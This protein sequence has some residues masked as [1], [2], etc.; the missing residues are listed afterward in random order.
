[1]SS[2]KPNKP[3]SAKKGA[4]G[5]KNPLP[6]KI[7]EPLARDT[8]PEVIC[9]AR[10]PTAISEGFIVALYARPTVGKPG[11]YRYHWTINDGNQ[12]NSLSVDRHRPWVAHWDTTG[13]RPGTFEATVYM[14]AMPAIVPEV[15]DETNFDRRGLPETFLDRCDISIP[16]TAR[17]FQSGDRVAVSLQRSQV[18]VTSDLALWVVIQRATEA[19]SFDNYQR[20]MDLLLCG[21]GKESRGDAPVS[22]EFHHL[23]KRRSL[24][25]NDADAYRLLKV[26]TE[27]FLMVNCGVTLHGQTFS[28]EEIDELSRRTGIDGGRVDFNAL[29]N[30]YLEDVNGYTDATIPY[31]AIIQRKLKD[32]PLKRST[33]STDRVDE[34]SPVSPENCVGILSRKLTNPCLLELIWSYW[35]EEAPLVQTMNAITLRFQN[36]SRGDRDPLRM[37]EVD[38]LRPLSNL[39]WGYLQDEQQRLSIPRRAL[40]YSH[41]YGLS[42][43]GKAVPPLHPADNRS[44]FLEAFHN[45]L[46]LCTVFYGGDDDTTVIADGFPLLN[47]LRE[48]HFLLAEGAHNQFGDL[49]STARQEMLIQQWLL[50]RPEF[51]GFLPTRVM[52]PLPEPWMDRVDAMKTLQ[53][54]TDVSVFHFNRLAVFGERILLSI[55]FGAWSIANDPSQAANWARFW[56]AEIQSYIHAYRSVTGVDLTVDITD[57]RQAEGRNLLPSIHLRNRRAMQRRVR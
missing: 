12:V 24:P 57:K 21:I 39:L 46:F 13:V 51:R 25:Y 27:A 45:L 35:Q 28:P 6:E 48:V 2:D 9:E 7:A 31:L 43:Q 26:A 33:F 56:R 55:R 20:F 16:V 49:P 5:Q 18:G 34:R 44:K 23:R 41:H 14:C 19:I 54:W 50:A 47:A 29:W 17:P 42:L 40:E 1:M 32:E 53:G 8:K 22:A 4:G 52:V 11:D 30:R 10:P 3:D 36:I 37:L 15:T 38:S